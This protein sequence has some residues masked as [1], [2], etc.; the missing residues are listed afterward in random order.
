LHAFANLQFQIKED[1]ADWYK[2]QISSQYNVNANIKQQLDTLQ[3]QVSCSV[4]CAE[5]AG[6]NR[7]FC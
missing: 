7:E 5:L 3:Q 6:G 4:L 2:A 1:F